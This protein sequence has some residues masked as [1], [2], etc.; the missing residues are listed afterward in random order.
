MIQKRIVIIGLLSI[1]PIEVV[2][3]KVSKPMEPVVLRDPAPKPSLLNRLSGAF[4]RSP[5]KPAQQQVAAPKYKSKVAT[6]VFGNEA[7]ANELSGAA[8]GGRGGKVKRAENQQE[9]ADAQTFTGRIESITRLAS[10]QG[11]YKKIDR[12]LNLAEKILKDNREARLTEKQK[13]DITT[14]LNKAEKNAAPR[15]ITRAKHK[16]QNIAGH[17]R[18]SRTESLFIGDAR[19]ATVE[20]NPLLAGDLNK[21]FAKRKAPKNSSADESAIQNVNEESIIPGKSYEDINRQLEAGFT[22]AKSNKSA[23]IE[24]IPLK[25]QVDVQ[26]ILQRPNVQERIAAGKPQIIAPK[27]FKEKAKSPVD[28][29]SAKNAQ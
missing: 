19:V 29:E 21:E 12:F 27:P 17:T 22:T 3:I 10:D 4:S 25:Q 2:A 28:R 5:K 24:E 8:A 23:A 20:K 1:V 18:N 26:A 9:V 13:A 14:L 16:L 15:V 6:P 7:V 11:R